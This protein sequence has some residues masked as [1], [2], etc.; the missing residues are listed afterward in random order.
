MRIPRNTIVIDTSSLA[1]SEKPLNYIQGKI[2]D[3]VYKLGI[4]DY[5]IT[6]LCEPILADCSILITTGT[7]VKELLNNIKTVLGKGSI[8]IIASHNNIN[9]L[10][11]NIV[12]KNKNKEF[13]LCILSKDSWGE[14]VKISPLS[15]MEGLSS[16]NCKNEVESC[17][18]EIAN[19]RP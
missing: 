2:S 1:F 19:R 6:I 17:I 16:V 7:E 5:T 4:E 11:E 12:S 3:I 14:A 13:T 15:A 8:G 9:E 18:K 10:L